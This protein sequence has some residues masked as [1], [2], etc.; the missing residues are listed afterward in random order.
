MF[1]LF[2]MVLMFGL[3]VISL[4]FCSPVVL[5]LVWIMLVRLI[6]ILYVLCNVLAFWGG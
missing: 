2:I 3:I 4:L 6:V 1:V 5:Y